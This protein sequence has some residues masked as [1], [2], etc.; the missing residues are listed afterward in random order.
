M[1]LSTAT[2]SVTVMAD[3]SYASHLVEEA[4]REKTFYHYNVAYHEALKLTN[5]IEKNV[6]LG[7]LASIS[8]I[9]WRPDIGTLYNSLL[10]MVKTESGRIYDSIQVNIMNADIPEVDKQY[11]LG[12]VTSWGRRLVWTSDYGDGVGAIIEAWTKMDWDSISKAE[13]SLGKIKNNYSRYYL[14]EEL[15]KI[16]NKYNNITAV[17]SYNNNANIMN[18][19]FATQEGDWVY[20]SNPVNGGKLSK[21]RPGSNRVYKI[22][23]DD[24]LFISIMDNWIYY[25]NYSDNSSIYKVAMDGTGRTKLGIEDVVYL[26]AVNGWVYYQTESEDYKLY[27][28]NTDG[29]NKIVITEDSAAFVNIV[30]EYI[31]YSNFSYNGEIIRINSEG[32][33]RTVLNDDVSMYANVWGDW[34]YYKDEEDK[35]IYKIKLDGTGRTLLSYND[36]TDLNVVD[37]W[38]YYVNK[39][40]GDLLYRVSTDGTIE[41]KLTDSSVDKINTAVGRL[42][43]FDGEKEGYLMSMK[44]DKTE[45]GWFGADGVIDSI[46]N[47]SITVAKGDFFELPETVIGHMSDGSQFYFPVAWDSSKVDTNILGT[48]FYV[49][50]VG[51]Y[52]ARILL[53]LTVAERGNTNSNS[54]NKSIA[55]QKDGYIYFQGYPDGKLYKSKEDGTDRIELSDHSPVSINVIGEWAYYINYS[56]HGVLYKIKT[57]GSN[58]TKV[59]GEYMDSINIVGEWIF[60]QNRMDNW[61]LY[62]IKTDGT[63]K[64]KLSDDDTTNIS[65]SGEWIYYMDGS[66]PTAMYRVK[67]DGTAKEMIGKDPAEYMVVEGDTVYYLNGNDSDRLYKVKAD[68]T[69]KMKLSDTSMAFI[70]VSD[71]RIYF[72]PM[73]SGSGLHSITT[74]GK[75]QKVLTNDTLLI[76]SSSNTGR[77]NVLGDWIYYINHSDF[78]KNYRVKKDG[79]SREEFGYDT[80]LSSIVEAERYALLG[81]KFTLP[82]AVMGIMSDG[83]KREVPVNWSTFSPGTNSLG[84]FTYEGT[85]S[86]YSG[87]IKLILNVVKELPVGNSPN[88]IANYGLVA[89]NG[90]WIYHGDYFGL[91]KTS[92][93]GAGKTKIFDKQASHINVVGDWIY[94]MN[95]YHLGGLYRVKNDGS[96]LM[97]LSQTDVYWLQVVGDWIYYLGDGGLNRMKTDGTNRTRLT[98]DIVGSSNGHILVSEGW[99][100]YKN[101][102]QSGNLYKMRLDGSDKTKLDDTNI[103]FINVHQDWLYYGSS[104]GFYKMKKDG[105]HKVKVADYV[106]LSNVYGDW[107]YLV[108]TPNYIKMNLDGTGVVSFEPYSGSPLSIINDWIYFK[109]VTNGEEHLYRIRTDGTG[110]ELFN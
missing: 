22:I 109:A 77:I 27:R 76:Y 59:T 91:Y 110:K 48:S 47:P 50:T 100:Y 46:K 37:N 68:G 15:T 33:G 57:D 4:L 58:K 65:I 64:T 3:S 36:G 95:G 97:K 34:I 71:G 56:E 11:L 94:F 108:S 107:I 53:N 35:H 49:G 69:G 44:M 62:K 89:Q 43:F 87:K 66:G 29:T 105:T 79:S 24:A 101:D 67:Q 39:S 13:T 12:E 99:I 5:E 23:D 30:G 9:A 8:N 26:Y 88:N 75:D 45:L 18:Y 81:D 21:T 73:N 102:S 60:Y 93:S 61:K 103:W 84:T 85:V 14:K 25:V 10:D 6:L 16:N 20:Y 17:P 40:N 41:E 42:F 78:G 54:V 63:G 90:Q 98:E 104:A 92:V 1:V 96:G 55:A 19:G 32:T 38:I 28:M 86:N 74:E 7:K 80:Q 82:R 31:Y 83:T 51:Y 70:N 72:T 106:S 52:P 2:G